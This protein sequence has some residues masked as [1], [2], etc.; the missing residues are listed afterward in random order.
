[1]PNDHDH[2]SHTT[3][4]L[5]YSHDPANSERTATIILARKRTTSI[6]KE[7]PR[8]SL[9]CEGRMKGKKESAEGLA[10]DALFLGVDVGTQ[11][12]K[13]V[14]YDLHSKQVS[15]KRKEDREKSKMY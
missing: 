2:H 14:I 4:S 13:A 11:G 5:P 12:V 1:M 6:T 9:S 7:R 15:W 10:D 8:A 3:L